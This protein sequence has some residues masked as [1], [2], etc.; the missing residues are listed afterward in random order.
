MHAV[1]DSDRPR[2]LSPPYLPCAATCQFALEN[3][4][5]DRRLSRSGRPRDILME[6]CIRGA[7][8]RFA[9]VQKVLDL[10]IFNLNEIWLVEVQNAW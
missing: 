2:R 1:W 5:V 3:L 8:G 7:A 9:S 10:V 6:K 4:I